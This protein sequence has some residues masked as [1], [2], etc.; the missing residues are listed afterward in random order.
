MKK[1]N[2]YFV[3]RPCGQKQSTF[4]VK[5]KYFLPRSVLGYNESAKDTFVDLNNVAS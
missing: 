2:N 1:F 4:S 5:N 3:G